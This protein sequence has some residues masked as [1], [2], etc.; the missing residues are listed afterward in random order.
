MGD[1]LQLIGSIASIVGVPLAIY[2]FLKSQVQKYANVRR[3]VVKRLSYQI[4]EGRTISVFELNAIIDSIVRENRLKKGAISPSSV[5]EDLIAE[6]VSSPLLESSRKEELV[7][8]LSHIHSLGKVYNT[9]ENDEELFQKFLEFLDAKPEGK[10]KSEKIASELEKRKESSVES[11][12]VPEIF[13]IVATILAFIGSL[14]SFTSFVKGIE[15][16]P[17]VLGSEVVTSVLMSVLGSV[18]AAAIAFAV[19]KKSSGEK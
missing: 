1:V 8:E 16:I 14:A 4:G 19:S 12:K 9:L 17:K 5:I 6:T 13:A 10:E 18:V 15:L 11:S 7:K 2:L 3:E